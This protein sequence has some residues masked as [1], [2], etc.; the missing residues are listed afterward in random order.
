MSEKIN[1]IHDKFVRET[2][3][4]KARAISFFE[5]VL[6]DA[7]K[8]NLDISSLEVLNTSYMTDE[9]K[10]YFSDLVF[11]IQL[12]SDREKKVAISLLFEHKS[13]PDVHVSFQVGHYIFSQYAKDIASNTT[14][15]PIIPVI[16]YQGTKTW[17]VLTIKS[18]FDYCPEAITSYLH[19]ANHIFIA[20]KD[21][22]DEDIYSVTNAM[23]AAALL[24]QKHRFDPIRL[25]NDF[26]KILQLIPEFEVKRN[27][28]KTI[29]VYTLNITEIEEV[30]IANTIKQLPP[31]L[32]EN[33]M[34]TYEKIVNR[35]KMEGKLEGKLEGKVE[36]MLEG[37][38][39]VVLNSF[40][41]GIEIPL[42]ANITSM[43][44]DQVTLILKEHGKLI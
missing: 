41:S 17:K 38:I 42:I 21:M 35:N 28:L 15:V 16:Y 36:G 27:F 30:D 24:A 43:S 2:F 18:Y 14:L 1:N 20:L 12:I 4:D 40:D 6:P 37:K 26:S 39:E 22:E 44:Q 29:F 11:N 32:K 31:P 19:D 33:I 9:L 23:L 3:S 8:T 5:K 25:V 34:S 13:Q 10:E 7:L